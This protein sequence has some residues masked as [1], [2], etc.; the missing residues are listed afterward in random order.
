MNVCYCVVGR[1]QGATVAFEQEV[2]NSEKS[3]NK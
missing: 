2:G 1:G 3:W